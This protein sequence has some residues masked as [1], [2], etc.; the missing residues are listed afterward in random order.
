MRT[1]TFEDFKKLFPEFYNSVKNLHNSTSHIDYGGHKIDHDITVSMLAVKIIKDKKV[2][3][4]A[5]CAAML[6]SVDR[7]VPKEKI[8]A[9][10]ETISKSLNHFFNDVEIKEIIEA[11][12]R[13]SERNQHNQSETQQ[14][15]MD[16]DRLANMQYAV[17]I[18]GG[19]HRP[20]LPVFEF[21]YLSGKCNPLS[22]YESPKS[23]LDNLRIIITSY[24]EQLRIPK[25]KRLGDVYGKK[26]QK[27]I[28]SIEK[29]YEYLGLK[30]SVI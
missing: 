8:K 2:A 21:E 18:R 16:A 7:M 9:T 27:F 23:I 29:D 22:N 10:M 5:W 13:H 19:Q 1:K 14:V 6:H 25:A 12:F 17:I 11:A 26:L 30:N 15:L 4:K 3:K 24:T 20:N 28:T